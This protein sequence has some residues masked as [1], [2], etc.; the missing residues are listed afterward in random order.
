MPGYAPPPEEDMSVLANR[1]SAGYFETL[2][3]AVK[4]GRLIDDRDTSASP[5]VAVVNEAFAKRFLGAGA[6]G[7]HLDAG[8]H[9][10]TVVGVVADGKY[11]FD[12]LDK[13]APPFLYLPFA[14][15]PRA[16]I[17]MHMRVA[18]DPNRVFAQV[19]RA[20]SEINPALPLGAVTT[21]EEYTSLPLFPV[22][23]ATTVVGWLGA[24]ALLLAATGLYS[25][26]SYR[27][28]QRRPELAVRLALGAA[29]TRVLQLVLREGL[30]Q[31]AL[32]VSIG[33]ALALAL[34]H[35]IAARLPRVTATDPAVL[36]GAATT[37]LA[38]AAV[39]AVAPALQATRI[40]PTLALK[41]D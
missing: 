8:A 36:L 39:A 15:Q 25:V 37:L 23:L 9:R 26:L 30:M 24:V 7:R 29:P 38:V 17:T 18:G 21:M 2:G 33:A 14:Q 11:Q 1:V 22:R 28:S 5:L 16:A 34:M 4:D 3:I 13:P 35:L 27:V 32:G 10:L 6:V 19:R 31:A 40:E 20:V 41:A 12:A